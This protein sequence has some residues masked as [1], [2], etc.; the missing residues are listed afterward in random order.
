MYK[1]PAPCGLD[2]DRGV[3]DTGWLALVEWGHIHRRFLHG[4]NSAP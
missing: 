2:L 3:S 4:C 1:F